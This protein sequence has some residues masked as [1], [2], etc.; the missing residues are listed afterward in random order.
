[1]RAE[2]ASERVTVREALCLAN[3]VLKEAQI[4]TPR[5]DAE[6]LLAHHLALTRSQLLARLDFALDPAI[7]EGYH[8]LVER[9]RLHEPVAYIVGYKEFYG[10]EIQ[11]DRRVPI[12]RPETEILVEVALA[13][14]RQGRSPVVEVGTGSG[15]VAVALAVNLPQVEIYAT[16]LSPAALEIAKENCRHH[17][18][19]DRIFL[20]EGDLLEPLSE[21]VALVVANLPYLSRQE[22]EAT[23]PEVAKYEPRWAFNGGLDGLDH[24][25]RLFAQAPS[26]LLP[27]ANICLE[28]GANQAQ[29][30]NRIAREQFPK[31]RV[32]VIKDLAGLDRVV[33]I[34]M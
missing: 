29:T 10:L 5:L 19:L 20:L 28:V 33:F 34:M 25:R 9:R 21:P 27:R 23:P 31:A 30:I 24:Y 4:E 1:V 6:V 32:A 26:H 12:P 16:D 15:A 11:V 13:S 8:A 22:L 7:E 2:A 3:F 17:N 14:A 18:V